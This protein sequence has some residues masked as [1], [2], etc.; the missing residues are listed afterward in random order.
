MWGW[1]GPKKMSVWFE[2]GRKSHSFGDAFFHEPSREVLSR[3]A[4]ATHEVSLALATHAVSLALTTPSCE[5]SVGVPRVNASGD[6]P[7]NERCGRFVL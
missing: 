7:P 1:Q 3:L 5:V 2:T 6:I 4:L